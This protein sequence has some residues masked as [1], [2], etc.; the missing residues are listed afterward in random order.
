MARNKWR[1]SQ[2]LSLEKAAYLNCIGRAP[3]ST[4]LS[5]AAAGREIK[6]MK[7]IGIKRSRPL[8]GVCREAACEHPKKKRVVTQ[9]R[10]KLYNVDSPAR[11]VM[12]IGKAQARRAPLYG[13]T[14]FRRS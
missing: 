4:G 8:T 10:R 1:M 3:S 12:R 14:L 7:I 11:P 6:I 13:L 9:R 5:S 2:A